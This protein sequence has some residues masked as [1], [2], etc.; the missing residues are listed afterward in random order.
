MPERRRT[1]PDA[2]RIIAILKEIYPEAICSLI[3]EGDPWKL[4][5]MAVFPPNARTSV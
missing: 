2:G 3:W 5:V 4:L 1:M